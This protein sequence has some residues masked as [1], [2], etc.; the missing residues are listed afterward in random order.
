MKPTST[1]RYRIGT[2]WIENKKRKILQDKGR[3]NCLDETRTSQKIG[4]EIVSRCHL[5]DTDLRHLSE[6]RGGGGGDG[7]EG[8]AEMQGEARSDCYDCASVASDG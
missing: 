3:C 2:R 1:N 4:F 7:G 5:Y 8:S 6:G